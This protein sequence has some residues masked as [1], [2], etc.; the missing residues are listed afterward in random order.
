M[1]VERKERKR[2]KQKQEERRNVLFVNFLSLKEKCDKDKNLSATID[3]MEVL[4]SS[5]ESKFSLS[6]LERDLTL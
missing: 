1:K 3:A 6:I 5:L 2:R 4:I